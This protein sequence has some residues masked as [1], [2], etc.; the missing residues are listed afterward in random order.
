VLP[1]KTRLQHLGDGFVT[2]VSLFGPQH[3]QPPLV[4]AAVPARRRPSSALAVVL[5]AAALTALPPA[6][7]A[8]PP[9]NDA[10]TSPG[11]FQPFTAEN[12]TPTEFQATAELAEATPDFGVP[13]CL[14]PPSFARTV[15][16]VIPAENAPHEISVEASG[17]TLDVV[18]LAAFVQ[19]QDA[20]GAVVNQPNACDGLGAGGD[21]AA[22]EP[23]SGISLRV[24]A[25]RA[26]LVQVGR[27]G[28]RGTPDNERA[29]VSLDDRG[30]PT[31]AAAPP[32]DAAGPATPLAASNANNVLPL[33][34]ATITEEDP[35]EPPC[36]SL[37]S[38][39]RKVVP[40]RTGSRLITANGS[41]AATLTVFQGA[42]P[43]GDNVLDCVDRA[44]GGALQMLVHARA[45]KPLW[46]RIGTDD[47][48]DGSTASL[49]IDPGTGKFV[50][51]GGPGGFD[52][53]SF[54][55]GG[56]FPA[57]CGRADASKASLSG[58]LFKGNLK[59][60]GKRGAL[61]LTAT[62][63][64]GPLCDFD[65]RLVGPHGKVYAKARSIRLK[66]GRRRIR[67]ART[68]KLAR[69]SYTLH[70]TALD[71]LGDPVR[72]RSTVKAK[73]A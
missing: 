37:G 46:I 55:P 71:A 52:P 45:H 14:G 28:A 16:Y 62:I 40:A 32:G 65:A 66:G 29:I 36:P 33:T 5:T 51:D 56:G 1:L 47:P 23:T 42:A 50:V 63:K 10:P 67:L 9:P 25:G 15:W 61:T 31:P 8:A 41:Q 7:T 70:V 53:S 26:V 49:R 24:P 13:R 48:P 73:L 68:R 64:K 44:G 3:T 38:V 54:G 17:E 58:P 39:W 22:E 11:T 72:V 30:L 19:P 18:D 59:Q 69:G 6:A 34:G 20:A 35:A 12:G 57:E 43:T 27:R 4:H 2:N 21:A 60:L